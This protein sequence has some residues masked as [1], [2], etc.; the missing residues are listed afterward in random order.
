LFYNLFNCRDEAT[1]DVVDNLQELLEVAI[2]IKRNNEDFSST[3]SFDETTSS[4]K[5]M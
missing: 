1:C 5:E 3:S 4:R 2:S